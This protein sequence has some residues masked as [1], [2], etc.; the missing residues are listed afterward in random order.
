V[1][2][3]TDPGRPALQDSSLLMGLRAGGVAAKARE[4]A[5]LVASWEIQDSVRCI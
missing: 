1:V 3:H 2:A 4:G 5:R